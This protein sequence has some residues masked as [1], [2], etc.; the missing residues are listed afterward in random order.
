M[1]KVMESHGISKPQKSTNP[2]CILQ[3]IITSGYL[4]GE[5]PR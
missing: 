2:T 3:K 4:C 5:I 1:E